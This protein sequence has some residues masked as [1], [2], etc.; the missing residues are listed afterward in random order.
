MSILNVKPGKYSF[1][2]SLSDDKN[3]PVPEAS[4]TRS[5]T[6]RKFEDAIPHIQFTMVNTGANI[7]LQLTLVRFLNCAIAFAGSAS[8]P[9]RFAANALTDTADVSINY[10][11]TDSPLDHNQFQVCIRIFN[12]ISQQLALK[13]SCIPSSQRAVTLRNMRKGN[14]TIFLQLKPLDTTTSS[15]I[16]QSA[17]DLSSLVMFS[18]EIQQALLVAS[19][20]EVLPSLTLQD[21]LRE[22]AASASTSTAD[23]TISYQIQG[24]PSAITQ[25]QTCLQ[26]F[27]SEADKMLLQLTC[28]PREHTEF[29]LSRMK[30]GLYKALLTLRNELVP[31]QLYPSTVQTV[32]IDIR[33]PVE[34]VPSYDWQPLR[35]WHTIPAAIETR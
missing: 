24:I 4:I 10:L 35:P 21:S 22:Y 12:E 16:T 17:M 33:L 8:S 23:V 11:L 26:I 2:S 32:L 5:L 15:E 1:V 28:V 30:V 14:Y 13:L 18:S 19:V 27:E 20:E 7:L 29:T 6:V 25:V 9:L 34:F 31:S 3:I